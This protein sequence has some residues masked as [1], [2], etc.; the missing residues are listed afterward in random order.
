MEISTIEDC[1]E[2]FA[3]VEAH[4]SGGLVRCYAIDAFL[5]CSICWSVQLLT[6]CS[7]ATV[8]CCSKAAAGHCLLGEPHSCCLYHCRVSYG[9]L[10][11]SYCMRRL[12]TPRQP[13]CGSATTS[14]AV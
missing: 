5:H 1:G 2:L 10:L 6:G 3:W 14:C 8:S 9:S 13:P 7:D 4:V 12:V 11:L